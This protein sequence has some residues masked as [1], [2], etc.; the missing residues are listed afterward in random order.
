V[1][2]QKRPRGDRPA[3]VAGTMQPAT[4]RHAA[5]HVLPCTRLHPM[6]IHVVKLA[7]S[8]ICVHMQQ[9]SRGDRPASVAG[10]TIMQVVKGENGL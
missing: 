8:Q 7:M 6:C 5:G 2:M 4:F 1:H 9:R 10:P 3:S